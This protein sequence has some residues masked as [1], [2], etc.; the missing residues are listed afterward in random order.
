[1]NRFFVT[2]TD[3]G[4]G[5]TIVST[6]LT[7]GLHAKYWKPIQTGSIEGTDSNF[8]KEWAGANSVLPETYV[9]KAP[10]SPHLASKLEDQTI[11]LDKV[12][13]ELRAYT[14]D[15]IIEGAGGVH[16]PID[17]GFL[18]SDLIQKTELPVI[19]AVNLRL[20]CI[21]HT[22]LTLEA[23]RSRQI[24]VTG[25]IS[26]GENNV[27]SSRSIEEYGHAQCLGHI[28]H[29]PSFTKDFFATAFQNLALESLCPN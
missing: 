20:G 6:T 13:S 25:F 17:S 14:G 4:I 15:L 26:V 19:V 10:V 1:M 7:I 24:P 3:T 21:N 9:F 5:K 22:L 12:L 29:C 16:V 27:E 18:L 28:P 23:L 2:G 8:V 11:D